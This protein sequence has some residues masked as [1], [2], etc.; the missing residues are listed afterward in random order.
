MAYRENNNRYFLNNNRYF[1]KKVWRTT[2]TLQFARF[3]VLSVKT[4][5]A[6]A[7]ISR[8]AKSVGNYLE[9]NNTEI[10]CER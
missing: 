2:H 4:K 8:L 5:K 1:L 9:I 3:A 7:I 6:F 10:I